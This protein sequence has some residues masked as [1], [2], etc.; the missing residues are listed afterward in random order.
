MNR[1]SLTIRSAILGALRPLPILIA[2]LWFLVVP[3]PSG[4]A[5]PELPEGCDAWTLFPDFNCEG[6]E[7]RAEGT[8]N[9]VGMPYLFEDPHITTGLNFIYIYHDFPND[10]VFMGGEAHVIAVQARLAITDRLAFIAT[11]DGL[12]FFRPD[13]KLIRD[14]ERSMDVTVGFKYAAINSP[15]YDFILSPAIRYEIPMGSKRIFQG[16][17]DGVMIPSMSWA[18]GLGDIGLDNFNMI[19]NLGGQIPLDRDQNST[20]IFYNLHLDYFWKIEHSFIKG[21]VPFVEM[22]GIHWTSGGDGTNTVVLRG[23]DLTVQGTQNALRTGRFEGADL[24]N[25][26]SRGVS[27]ND[28]VIVGGGLRIPTT[29]GVS[30]AA[31]YE[32]PA[33]TRED[34]WD[35]RFTFMVT[36]EF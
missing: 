7:G 3:V 35:Q 30:L 25:L 24:A 21:I 26:G 16:Y 11:K 32:A 20:S 36:L 12:M 29:W 2:G 18:W 31:Y 10:S 28:L 15:E 22:N 9:P 5:A 17:G 23:P 6:R 27:G 1:R 4:A 14:T 33:S 19:G 13:S 8:V 34:I